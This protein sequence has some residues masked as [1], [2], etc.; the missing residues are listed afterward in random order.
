LLQD[1]LKENLQ[2]L[3]MCI[4]TDLFEPIGP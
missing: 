4:D 2:G 1:E 3:D